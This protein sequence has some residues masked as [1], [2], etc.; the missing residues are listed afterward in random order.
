MEGHRKVSTAAHLSHHLRA[1]DTVRRISFKE[2]WQ[3]V[4]RG[5]QALRRRLKTSKV[6]LAC[7]ATCKVKRLPV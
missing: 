6:N 4:D 2:S 5:V 1:L 3:A 7:L